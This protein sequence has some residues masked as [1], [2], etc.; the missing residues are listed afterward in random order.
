MSSRCYWV[1]RFHCADVNAPRLVTFPQAGGTGSGYCWL[2]AGLSPSAEVLTLQY[3][4][5]QERRHEPLIDDIGRL[6]DEI[7]EVSGNEGWADGRPTAFFGHSMGATV[8]FEVARRLES[9]T[10]TVLSMLFISA[11]R[12]PSQVRFEYVHR[13]DD[14]SLLARLVALNRANARLVENE[15]ARSL[16]MPVIRSDYYAMEN[17]RYASGPKLNCPLTVLVGDSDPLTTIEEAR[18][19]SGHT[20]RNVDLRIFPG[21]HFYID[22]HR[23]EVIR[24]IAER[25]EA[26]SRST[27]GSWR[28]RGM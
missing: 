13:G 17:Y 26:C 10:G 9:E 1:R 28:P 8:A 23:A 16:I 21:G 19:W 14:E 15:K 2:S 3:P 25:L 20:T 27:P 4:G 22:T 12:A 7:C 11:C 18:A 6:A 24:V 5:R